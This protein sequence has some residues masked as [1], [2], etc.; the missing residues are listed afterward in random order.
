MFD[1][2]C[3]ELHR[4]VIERALNRNAAYPGAPARPK[5]SMVAAS[6]VY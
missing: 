4:K 2:E 5:V 1:P 6:I 3:T